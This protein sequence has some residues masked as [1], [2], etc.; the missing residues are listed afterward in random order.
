MKADIEVIFH[1]NDNRKLFEGYRPTHLIDDKNLTTGVH[2]YYKKEDGK[3]E[4]KG[5]IEFIDPEY[6]PHC[7]W[8]GKKIDMYEGKTKIGYIEILRIFNSIL[9]K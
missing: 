6:Y 2:H 7:L 3:T 8:I 1:F 5:T 9:E 4:V